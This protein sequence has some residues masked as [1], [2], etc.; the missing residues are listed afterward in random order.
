MS[1]GESC[2]SCGEAS[3]VAADKAA[4]PAPATKP[5]RAQAALAAPKS[6]SKS[7]APPALDAEAG[8]PA[9]PSDDDPKAARGKKAR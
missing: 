3:W 7:E 5:A 8:A 9:E 2:P 4:A 6:D 1:M